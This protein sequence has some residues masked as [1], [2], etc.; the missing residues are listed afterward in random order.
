MGV[1]GTLTVA[2][3]LAQ[4]PDHGGHTWVFLQYLLGLRRLGWDVLFLDQLPADGGVDNGGV[5]IP[6]ECCRKL[7]H[8]RE[9]MERVGLGDSHAVVLGD[10]GICV[11]ASRTEVLARVRRSTILLNVM[12]F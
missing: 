11:G 7:E 4:K 8:V 5:A 3:S 10:S 1:R 12:G 9:V 2:G 6:T